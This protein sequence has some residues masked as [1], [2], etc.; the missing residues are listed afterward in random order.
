MAD[1]R[2][3]EILRRLSELERRVSQMVVRGKIHAVDPVKGM[4][5]VAYGPRGQQQLTGWIPWK[6][7]RAA[8]AVVWWCPEVGEGV[9]VVSDG[10]LSLGEI[11][12]GSYQNDFPAP[13][14]D[15][16]EFLIQFGDGSKV[17][18]NRANHKLEVVNVGDVNITTQQNIHVKC[19]G[20]AT[21]NAGG[22]IIANGSKV[23]LN[24][25]KGVVTGDCVCHFTGKPHGDISSQVT[26]GK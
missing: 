16:D 17:S 22:E 4:A 26:A 18:H 14:D 11:L 15:P 20:K 12:P 2:I 25:G 3:D 9:T 6:P 8:K 10:D 7:I 5:R 1:H 13:S 19:N 24:G 23:K 21:V